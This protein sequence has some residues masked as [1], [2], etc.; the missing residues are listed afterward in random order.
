MHIQIYVEDSS[1]ACLLKK[2]LPKIIGPDGDPHTWQLHPYKG[3]GHLPKNLAAGAP[4]STL[5]LNKLPALLRGTAKTSGIDAIVVVVDV[6]SKNCRNFLAELKT[7]AQIN[8]PNLIVMFRLAIEEIEAWYFGDRAAVLTA[9]PKAK[10][11]ELDKYSQDSIC[12]TWECLADAVHKG[13]SAALRRGGGNL[14]GKS[15]MNGL[16]R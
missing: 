13:G 4:M 6:D 8:S 10:I 5:L 15:S 16:K 12:G 7:V 3:V 1:G 11:K 14:R 9:Y 2:L